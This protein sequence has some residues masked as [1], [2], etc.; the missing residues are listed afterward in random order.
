MEAERIKMRTEYDIEMLTEV[1]YVNGVE[2]YS[3]YLAGR[4]MGDPPATLM[5]FFPQDFITFV[6]ESH[7]TIP[8]I[9]GMYAGDRARKENLVN[10]GFRLPSALENRPLRFH[11][12]EKKI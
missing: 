1:G 3:M 12:F 4:Q 6:D 5:D 10:Y 9:G 7:I 11:E 8:Q 2:N